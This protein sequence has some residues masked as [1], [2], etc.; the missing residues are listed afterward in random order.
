MTALDDF[1]AQLGTPLRTQGTSALE[2]VADAWQVVLPRNVI[3]VLTAYGDSVIADQIYLYGP[4]TLANAGTYAGAR[5]LPSLDDAA[6]LEALPRPGGLLLWASTADGDSF[7]LRDR[8]DSRWTVSY[9]DGQNLR[10]VHTEEE[11]SDWLLGGLIGDPKYDVLPPWP[12]RRP[13]RVAPFSADPFEAEAAELARSAS[14]T[15]KGFVCPVCRAVGDLPA[16][17]D[18]WCPTCESQVDFTIE[19]L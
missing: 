8:G 2:Q 16:A 5:L 12:R 9:C 19:D 11:F 1:V 14:S 13:H 15:Q 7:C 6:A 4:Q 10:W 3:D 18:H 17:L